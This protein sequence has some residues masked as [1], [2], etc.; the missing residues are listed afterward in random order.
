LLVVIAIIAILIALLLPAVQQAREAARRTAC[1][2]N[3]V[4]VILAVHNY[5]MAYEVLP[6]GTVNPTGPI[7][8]EPKGYHMSWTVQLLPYLE[9]TAAFRAIDFKKDVY[10]AANAEVRKARLPVQICPSSPFGGESDGPGMSSYAACHH[11]TE[12]SIDAK[13]NG[14]LFLN[15]SVRFDEI[16]DGSS[17]TIFFGEKVIE[18]RDRDRL[19][20][21]GWMSGTRATLRNTGTPPNE[22]VQALLGGR[23]S[24]PDGAPPKPPGDRGPLF[25]GG[26]SSHHPG[27]AHFALGDGSVRF[28]SQNIWPTVYQNLGNRADG[29]IVGDKF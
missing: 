26:F 3:L 5:E 4:Q 29:K 27:G 15:S 18:P 17:N 14:V 1:K 23:F 25:V 11:A 28:L 12:S 21:L 9:Q 22:G 24:G 6:P 20:D 13:N 10:D 8:S 2:N 16:T 19:N 7:R